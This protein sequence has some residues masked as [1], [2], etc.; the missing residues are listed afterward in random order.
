M[1]YS[2]Y[3]YIY[4]LNVNDP[5]HPLYI[6][7]PS[8]TLSSFQVYVWS[9]DSLRR[10]RCLFSS[11]EEAKLR[12]LVSFSGSLYAIFGSHG[13]RIVVAFDP[14]SEAPTYEISTRDSKTE[15]LLVSPGFLVAV[16]VA[17]PSSVH[18]AVIT[19]WK[20]WGAIL[21]GNFL[22]PYSLSPELLLWA[23]LTTRSSFRNSHKKVP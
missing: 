22:L 10:L 14:S 21:L 7:T 2:E 16:G 19:V 3:I 15:K 1:R 17:A 4:L 13:S 5:I 6:Q 8:Q 18:N 23:V 20:R 12:D 9:L 11:D